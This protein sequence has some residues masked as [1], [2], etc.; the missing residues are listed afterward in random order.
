VKSFQRDIAA[1]AESTESCHLNVQFKHGHSVMWHAIE[2][3][4]SGRYQTAI[5]DSANSSLSLPA[6]QRTMRAI[7]SGELA[8]LAAPHPNIA[9]SG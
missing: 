6:Q 2:P 9:G 8:P 1:A 5:S 3:L 4:R 7:V